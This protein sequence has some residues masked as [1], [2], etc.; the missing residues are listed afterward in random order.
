MDY[1]LPKE[2]PNCGSDSWHNTWR[3][4]RCG[5]PDAE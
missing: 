3:C 4:N 2:C 1:D 5:Y